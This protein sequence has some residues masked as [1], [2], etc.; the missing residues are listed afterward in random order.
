MG[1]KGS[2]GLGQAKPCCFGGEG[3]PGRRWAGRGGERPLAATENKEAGVARIFCGAEAGG[4]GAERGAVVA[5][6][7][8]PAAPMP[9]PPPRLG[10]RA[11]LG[12]RGAARALILS[13]ELHGCQGRDP[14]NAVDKDHGA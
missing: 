3:A 12:V 4:G 8:V 14:G 10:L 13:P 9:A 1:D 5:V 2:K 11:R 7:T 6:G